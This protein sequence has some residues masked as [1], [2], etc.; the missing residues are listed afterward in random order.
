MIILISKG[1]VSLLNIIPIFE[2]KLS[3][4]ISSLPLIYI[5]FK[6]DFLVES[7]RYLVVNFKFKEA[8]ESLNNIAKINDKQFISY[9][10][11]EEIEYDEFVSNLQKLT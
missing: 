8:Y 10:L 11:K 9:K 2:S 6:C 1:L 7:P 5:I 3:I 4:A